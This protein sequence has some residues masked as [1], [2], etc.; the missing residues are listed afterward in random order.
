[1][2]VSWLA[3]L[4]LVATAAHARPYDVNDLLRLESYGQVTIDPT[5]RWAVFDRRAPYETAARF[6]YGFNVFRAVSKV[7]LVDLRRPG[8]A[9]PAFPQDGNAGYWIAGF[10]PSGRRLAVYRLAG[11]RLALGVADLESRSVLWLP[12]APDLPPPNPSPIW[13]NDDELIYVARPAGDLPLRLN[14]AMVQRRAAIEWHRASDGAEASATAY[15]SGAFRDLGVEN[16]DT[17]VVRVN[18]ATGAR[19]VL[20]RGSI[21]DIAAS[22]DRRRLAIVMRG[23]VSQPLPD[24]RVDIAFLSRRSRLVVTDLQSG[25]SRDICATCDVLPNL[26][27]W[28]SSGQELLFFA[29][30]DGQTW[31]EG[32]LLR[33]ADASEPV[34]AIPPSLRGE[35]SVVGGSAIVVR[36]GW[37]GSDVVVFARD[38]ASQPPAWHRLRPQ[39]PLRLPGGPS[40]RLLTA[41]RD[42]NISVIDG[43]LVRSTDGRPAQRLLEGR[44][45]GVG[46][47]ALDPYSVGNRFYF[48]VEL[49]T[50]PPLIIARG[51]SRR[52]VGVSNDSGRV[53]WTVMLPTP[54]TQLLASAPRSGATLYLRNDLKGVG[55]LTFAEPG[56]RTVTVDRINRHLSETDVMRRVA[57]RSIGPDG[58]QL[59]HWLTVPPGRARPPLI[60]IPYPGFL[61]GDGP[62][63]AHNPS[64]FNPVAN[65]SLFVSAGYAVLEPSMPLEA[66]ARSS[67][68]AETTTGRLVVEAG[69]GSD[70]ASEDPF[71]TMT[72]TVL[73]AIDAAAATGRIDPTRVAVYGHSYGA[74]AAVAMA[75]RT[76]RFAAIVAADGVYDLAATYGRI[77]PQTDLAE[78]GI[79]L[80]MTFG[81][82]ETGQ[83]GLGLPPW[84]IP[85]VY[86][87]RSPYYSVDRIRT[88][89]MLIQGELDYTPYSEAER[90]F[91]ALYRLNRDAVLVRYGGEG[92]VSSSPAN[93]RDQWTR[94]F[95]FLASRL[96]RADQR[97]Q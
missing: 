88:P 43:H 58:S 97:P 1:M 27:A 69:V 35:V 55:T 49:D 9:V 44:V 45:T 20:E 57:I 26:L 80:A 60:V 76:D 56:G 11:E 81:W 4:C 48:N 8:S 25:H 94:T 50:L 19:S 95:D 17:M 23:P 63:P 37:A 85:E 40:D 79:V 12:D 96:Q 14:H 5:E 32:L 33:M 34:A 31:E 22:A 83:G 74:Y 46:A 53:N 41:T 89:V 21:T 16:D 86:R 68:T 70:Q 7:H 84:Q 52:V 64:L 75:T 71:E 62:P 87:R 51:E 66:A 3:G 90:M 24:Q 73:G 91:M 38:G 54:E 15:G 6:D 67:A 36:A 59:T 78:T 77:V 30:R 2:R 47:E 82:F 28:S 65:P 39:G 42:N 72:R 13:L 18:V 93:I 10:S 29:R 61:R 92:H